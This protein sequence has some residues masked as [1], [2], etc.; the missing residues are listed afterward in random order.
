MRVRENA[1]SIAFYRGE[2]AE[3]KQVRGRFKG[4]LRNYQRLLRQQLNLNF[5]QQ[6]YNQIAIILPNILIANLVLSGQLEVGQAI[7]AAG[8]LQADIE[9]I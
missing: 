8:A 1:E 2:Q 4:A 3:L 5:F 9:V 6:A 7:K